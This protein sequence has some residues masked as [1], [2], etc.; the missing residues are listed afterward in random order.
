M[1][2][3][4]EFR[5]DKFLEDSLLWEEEKSKLLEEMDSLANLQRT[6]EQG[7][8]TGHGDSV[9]TAVIKR[10]RLQVEVDRLNGYMQALVYAWNKLSELQRE[11]LTATI[12]S[13]TPRHKAIS[14][15]AESHAVCINEAY[16]L[17]REALAE[18]HDHIMFWADM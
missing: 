11:V 12:L 2:R 17:R 8:P 16:K 5:T 4:M 9:G 1:Y 14:G 3:Y 18:L 10:E 15:F 7:T 13:K 6:G